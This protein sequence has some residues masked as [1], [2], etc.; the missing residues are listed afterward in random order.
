YAINTLFGICPFQVCS[1]FYIILRLVTVSSAQ[2]HMSSS[3]LSNGCRTFLF[4]SRLP[5]TDVNS[6]YADPIR[7]KEMSFR[8]YQIHQLDRSLNWP[9][10]LRN[11]PFGVNS[12]ESVR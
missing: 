12:K 6:P 8:I 7:T 9:H 10:L 11:S 5:Q 1:S 3:A 4:R 2:L